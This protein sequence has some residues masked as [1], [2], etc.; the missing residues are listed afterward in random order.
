MIA[1]VD[2]ARVL[3]I[4]GT[5][6][7]GKTTLI[8]KLATALSGYRMAGFYTEEIRE[9]AERQGFRL[10]GF[11]GEEGLIAHVDFDHPHRVSKY[12]VDVGA[13]DCLADTTLALSQAVDVY[14]V[15]EIGKME[16]MSP[17]F[18][19]RMTALLDSGKP[20]IATVA[21]KGGGLIEKVKERKDAEVWELTHANRSALV[22]EATRWLGARF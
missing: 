13:I 21:K 3:L 12:S 16:C 19:S 20:V 9:H 6:G 2:K 15:D 4:T 8:R 18:V 11:G 17:R 7:S 22:S 1:E 14:L 5:A 10:I